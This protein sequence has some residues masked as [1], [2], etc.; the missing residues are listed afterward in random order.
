MK[1]NQM[2]HLKPLCHLKRCK[3][4]QEGKTKRQVKGQLGYALVGLD[5]QPRQMQLKCKMIKGLRNN[6][7]G[8][9]NEGVI[10]HGSKQIR[11]IKF[12]KQCRVQKVN[13]GEKRLT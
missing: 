12:V 3:S 11:W 7:S 13:K 6:K 8:A 10:C 2:E 9:N 1:E 5:D 4:S